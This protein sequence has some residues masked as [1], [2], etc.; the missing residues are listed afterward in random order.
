MAEQF[1]CEV[2]VAGPTKDDIVPPNELARFPTQIDTPFDVDDE[3]S[4]KQW[5]RTEFG[6][7]YFRVF[8]PA[9]HNGVKPISRVLSP[10]GDTNCLWSHYSSKPR[11]TS[12]TR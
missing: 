4:I 6:P 3:Q 7:G 5:L 8:A 1:L 2:L 12:C 10:I 11:S 9:T